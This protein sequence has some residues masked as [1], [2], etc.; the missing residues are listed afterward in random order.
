V[1]NLYAVV[2]SPSTTNFVTGRGYLIRTPNNFPSTPTIWTASYVGTPFNGTLSIPVTN[3]TYNAVGNPYPS[4]IDADLFFDT[5]GLTEALYFYRK[6]N[7]TNATAYATY[8]KSGG[9]ASLPG[10][11]GNQGN[12][13][14]NSL[15]PDGTI[16]IG[17]GFIVKSTSG[18]IVFNNSM[19]VNSGTGVQ[20]RA[21]VERHRVWLNMTSAA[22][23]FSQTLIAYMTGATNGVDAAI[24]GRYF[25]DNQTALTTIINNQEYAIQGR[26]LPFV[27][28]DV[29]AIGFKTEFVGTYTISLAK[30]DGLFLSGQVIFLKDK[31]TNTY[32][33]IR[34]GSYTFSSVAGVFNDRFE[35][36][37]TEPSTFYEDADGDGFGNA[38]NFILADTAPQGY[39]SNASDCDDTLVTVNTNAS[40]IASNGIDD[41]CDG[42]IDE[43]TPLS[44]LITANCGIT[45]SNMSTLL[46]ARQLTGVGSVQGYRFRVTN[47]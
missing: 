42:N 36:R 6:T 44:S 10:D 46:Y 14:S 25:N 1:N 3:G 33:N 18:S 45:L 24:D 13:D 23:F 38:F 41:N 29:V 12:N 22:G 32:T 37:F 27:N 8:T 28:S 40:E 31:L 17:Q 21:G 2:S 11:N 35:L 20:L 16:A 5:N 4:A 15:A 39:V 19:R 34:T 43:V 47:G 26:Q 30:L 7:G 9:V